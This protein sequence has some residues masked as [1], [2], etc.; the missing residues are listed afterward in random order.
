MKKQDAIHDDQVLYN[1]RWV[2]KKHFRVMVYNASAK[3]IVNS[4][5]EYEREIAS[6]LWFASQDEAIP[7]QPVNIRTG[8]KAKD[9]STSADG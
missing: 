2:Q 6:G 1:G 7:K 4:Y 3:K 5:D 9:G 8:R